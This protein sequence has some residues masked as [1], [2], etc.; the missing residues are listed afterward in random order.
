[1][2]TR[3]LSKKGDDLKGIRNQWQDILSEAKIVANN[4][5]KDLPTDTEFPERRLKKRKRF[6][7]EVEG[8]QNEYPVLEDESFK[9]NVFYKIL[10][11]VVGG[12][13]ER[14]R[15]TKE[16]SE[17]FS[18][19]WKYRELNDEDLNQ[20]CNVFAKNY[21]HDVN[22]EICEEMIFLKSIHNSNIGPELLKPLQLSNSLHSLKL[23]K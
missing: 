14:F 17:S 21:N 1:M 8:S 9:I 2:L 7:D 20:K 16:L 13:T 23:E 19:L 5:S 15:T 12:L 3:H 18:F 22:E 6:S 4:M 11:S 10:D